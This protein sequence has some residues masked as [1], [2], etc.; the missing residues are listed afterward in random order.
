[1]KKKKY[2]IPEISVFQTETQAILAAV[3]ANPTTLPK[4]SEEIYS[5]DNVRNLW[6]KEESK[7]IWSD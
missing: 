5:D 7:D 3:S 6:E 1:M 2:I 4:A